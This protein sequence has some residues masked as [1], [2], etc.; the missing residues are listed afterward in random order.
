MIVGP[1]PP[2]G[3]RPLTTH[4]CLTGSMHNIYE[5]HGYSIGEDLL[6][7]LG[8]GVGFIYWHVKGTIPFFGDRANVGRQGSNPAIVMVAGFSVRKPSSSGRGLGMKPYQRPWDVL[9]ALSE[10]ARWI[11]EDG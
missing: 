3:F 2:N 4:H 7:G 11:P 10:A 8:A 1:E 5:F 9:P 6:L